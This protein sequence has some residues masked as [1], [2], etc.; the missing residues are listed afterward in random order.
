MQPGLSKANTAAQPSRPGATPTEQPPL[1]AGCHGGCS[2]PHEGL[3]A[4]SAFLWWFC[5]RHSP[6]S[7]CQKIPRL[8]RLPYRR[9]G[10]TL[11][12]N[13]QTWK[14]LLTVEILRMR[15]ESSKVQALLWASCPPSPHLA[16]EH[17]GQVGLSLGFSNCRVHIWV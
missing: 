5:S 7:A 10:V 9:R 17:V 15:Q 14:H 6:D 1:Q 8:K 13:T 11:L 16:L 4:P 12:P 2:A 3:L